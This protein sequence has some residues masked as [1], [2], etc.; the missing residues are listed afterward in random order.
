ML[1]IKKS[2]KIPHIVLADDKPEE[3]MHFMNVLDRLDIQ[4]IF[5]LAEN[6]AMLLHMLDENEFLPDIIFINLD[7]KGI[8]GKNCLVAIRS[9]KRLDN[10]PVIVYSKSANSYDINDFYNANANLCVGKSDFELTLNCLLLTVFKMSS[11]NL[12][13]VQKGELLQNICLS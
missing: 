9:C 4:H 11:T 7:M 10:V 8:S 3:C 12:I 13:P 6:G 1:I 5:S 2:G